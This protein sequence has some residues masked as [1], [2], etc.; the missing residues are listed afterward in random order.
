MP[1]PR[2]FFRIKNS[3]AN[4]LQALA[5]RFKTTPGSIVKM[6]VLREV[7]QIPALLD[8]HDQ[9]LREIQQFHRD[10]VATLEDYLEEMVDPGKRSGV[11]KIISELSEQS[12]TID[13]LRSAATPRASPF[14]ATLVQRHDEEPIQTSFPY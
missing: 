10:L 4:D 1:N 11:R 12:Q 7:S 9:A 6:I 2:I 13:T 5:K 14:I 3:V 8:E